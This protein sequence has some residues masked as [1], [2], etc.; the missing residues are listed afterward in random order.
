MTKE[1][2]LQLSLERARHREEAK[3]IG[4]QSERLIHMTLKYYLEP[5]EDAHEVKIG[6]YTADIFRKDTDHILE[7]QTRSFEKLENKL[8]AFLPEHKVTVI[9]PCVRYKYISWVDPETGETTKKHKSPR[10][11]RPVDALP[12]LYKLKDDLFL[13]GLSFLIILMDV[14]E[15]RLL[16]GY[17]KDKKHGSHR[18]ERLPLS[19]EDEILLSSPE[20]YKQFL[21]PDLPETFT[22][23]DLMKGMHLEGRRGSNAINVLERTGVIERCG[24]DSRKILFKRKGLIK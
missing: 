6:R 4:T 15:Y 18:M 20:D 9:Y 7:I 2:K 14:E 1:E 3:G 24:M 5:D 16:D 19:I 21:P 8:K 17:S 23:A 13:P 11:G 22:R 10:T 12:E